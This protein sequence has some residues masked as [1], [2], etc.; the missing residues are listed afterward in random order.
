MCLQVLRIIVEYGIVC[1]HQLIDQPI[2][3]AFETVGV[4]AALAETG[5]IGRGGELGEGVSVAC[6]EGCARN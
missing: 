5:D 2:G 1:G 3:I 6:E 4:A